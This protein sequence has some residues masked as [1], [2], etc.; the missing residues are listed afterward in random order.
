VN[1]INEISEIKGIKAETLVSLLNV[2]EDLFVKMKGIFSRNY[3]ED[4][5]SVDNEIDRTTIALARDGI[6]HLLP[7]GLFFKENLLSGNKKS[8]FEF[9]K[10]LRELKRQQKEALSFFQ[11]FDTAFFKLTLEFE[12]LLND[13]AKTGNNPLIDSFLDIPEK[14]T[15]NKYLAKIIELLP[16]ANQMRGNIPLLIDILKDIFSAAKI[17]VKKTEP[18]FSLFIIH[19]EGLKKEEY[20]NMDKEMKP[21]FDF[22]CQWFLPVEHHYDYRIKDYKKPFKLE[23]SLILDYNT[24]L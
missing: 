1:N 23:D 16:F 19:I 22:I 6:F 9:D 4:L 24:H 12:H 17:E 20:L 21:C 14:E 2:H 11:P 15:T 10:E 3:S 8:H 5:L 7:Q 13:F 18:L